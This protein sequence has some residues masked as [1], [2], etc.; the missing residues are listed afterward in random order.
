MAN[1]N[2]SSNQSGGPGLGDLWLTAR[3][4]WRLFMDDQVPIW[5]KAVPAL[6]LA[7]LISPVD[8]VVDLIPVLGQMDDIAVILFSLKFFID[9]AP[10]DRVAYHRA[11]LQGENVSDGDRT[12]DG[13]FKG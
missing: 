7:Y 3:L 11:M 6:G 8:L 5:L 9:N 12:I 1:Q 13:R 4:A 10:A 2:P